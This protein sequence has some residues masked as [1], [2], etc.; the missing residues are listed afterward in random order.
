MTVEGYSNQNIPCYSKLTL[1][2]FTHRLWAVTKVRGNTR[3]VLKLEQSCKLKTLLLSASVQLLLPLYI[4]TDN[5]LTLGPMSITQ[6]LH[7]TNWT[8]MVDCS[9]P[10][11]EVLNLADI[12]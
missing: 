9:L 8:F 5:N 4:T 6:H 10:F 3:T 2:I 7:N 11:S 12:S 1:R